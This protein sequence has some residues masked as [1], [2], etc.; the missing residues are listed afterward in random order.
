MNMVGRTTNAVGETIEVKSDQKG[1]GTCTTVSVPLERGLESQHRND[2]TSPSS[3]ASVFS[4]LS[5]GIVLGGQ[6]RQESTMGRTEQLRTPA[7]TMT[8]TSIERSCRY[9]GIKTITGSWADRNTTSLNFVLEEDFIKEIESVRA[10]LEHGDKLPIIMIPY[11]I[12]CKNSPSVTTVS[13]PWRNNSHCPCAATEH[14]ASPCSI[15]KIL[16]KISSALHRHEDAGCTTALSRAL[17]G[18]REPPQ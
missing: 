15:R 16:W 18:R 4:A 11:V 12:I 7:T 6:A 1:S 5:V 3:H 10:D 2:N 13:E 9:L 14:I 8:I 17:Q